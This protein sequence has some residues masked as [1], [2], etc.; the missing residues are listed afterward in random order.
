MDRVQLGVMSVL[1]IV[2]WFGYRALARRFDA[3]EREQERQAG[4]AKELLE[5]TEQARRV[6]RG[7]QHN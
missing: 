5:R 2:N 6:F 4:I 1:A 3:R 7:H